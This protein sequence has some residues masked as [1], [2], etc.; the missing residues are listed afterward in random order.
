M[1]WRAEVGRV[2]HVVSRHVASRCSYA[3][4]ARLGQ[5]D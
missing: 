3:A 4:P 1:N 5:A 2:E